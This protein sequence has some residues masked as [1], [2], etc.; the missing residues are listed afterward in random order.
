MSGQPAD[1][2]SRKS[3][4]CIM[5]GYKKLDSGHKKVFHADVWTLGQRIRTRFT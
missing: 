4:F 5:S 1:A 3:M 2:S